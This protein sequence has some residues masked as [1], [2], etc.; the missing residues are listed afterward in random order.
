MRIRRRLLPSSFPSLPLPDPQL[1]RSPVVQHHHHHPPPRPAGNLSVQEGTPRS[2]PADS[3]NQS[4]P[5]PSD[6]TLIMI[7][8]GKTRW[9]FSGSS[10]TLEVQPKELEV[11][12][13]AKDRKRWEVV[14]KKSNDSK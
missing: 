10:K 3:P 5:P 2:Q 6:Q 14:E 13:E 7:G 11:D 1:N 9:V 12:E 8:S 4:P